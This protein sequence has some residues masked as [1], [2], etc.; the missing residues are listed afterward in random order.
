M[1]FFKSVATTCRE[2]AIAVVLTRLMLIALTGF[3][4]EEAR[5][6]SQEAGFHH[7]FVKPLEQDTL[8]RLLTG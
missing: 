3:G 7:H 6:R 1:P 5:R 2:R 4:T 8:L